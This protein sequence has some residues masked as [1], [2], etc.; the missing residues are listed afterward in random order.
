MPAPEEVHCTKRDLVS[1][2]AVLLQARRLKISPALP[3]ARTLTEEL[4]G[5]QV[6]I[7]QAGGDT[8]GAWRGGAHDDLILSVALA[9]WAGE[10]DLP[11]RTRFS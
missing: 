8:Y 7:S 11:G 2:L 10:L 3:E 9:C 5:F 4:A 6:K 1:T